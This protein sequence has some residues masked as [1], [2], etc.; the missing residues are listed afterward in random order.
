M[1]GLDPVSPRHSRSN[2]DV[3]AIVILL[4]ISLISIHNFGTKEINPIKSFANGHSHNL[5]PSIY[6]PCQV[7]R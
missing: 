7:D 3:A 1:L 6:A 4:A 2:W 5:G